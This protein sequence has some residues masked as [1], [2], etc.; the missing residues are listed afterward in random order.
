[1]SS[2]PGNAEFSHE[3]EPA[4]DWLA[5]LKR[6]DLGDTLDLP[7][8]QAGDI[9]LVETLNSRYH[10]TCEDAGGRW[11]EVRCDRENRPQGQ[12]KLMGCTWGESS[13][14]APDQLFCGGSLE[15]RQVTVDGSSLT[16]HSS[17][18]RKLG[19]IQRRR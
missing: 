17:S 9:L 3:S 16:H 7:R 12:M 4:I 19:W 2:E 8:I 1:M 6:A 11:F 14:I 18:I 5:W 15:L 10:L 13:S